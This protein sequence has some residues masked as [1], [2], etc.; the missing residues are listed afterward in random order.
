MRRKA[1]SIKH[2]YLRHMFKKD[3]KS[4]YTLAIVVSADPLSTT[5]I[6]F[7]SYEHSIKH[8]RVP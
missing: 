8:R 4:V 3:S 7:F 2:A 1:S 5:Q 6:N